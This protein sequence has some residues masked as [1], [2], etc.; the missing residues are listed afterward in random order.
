M[1]RNKQFASRKNRAAAGTGE[2]QVSARLSYSD[3]ASRVTERL[4]VHVH[5]DGAVDLA[6]RGQDAVIRPSS[7]SRFCCADLPKS[8]V[9]NVIDF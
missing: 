8:I 4:A 9:F 1:V 7:N 6:G 3:F 5:D 2:G